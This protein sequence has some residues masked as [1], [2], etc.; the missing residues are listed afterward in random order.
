VVHDLP[1]VGRN[2]Q[3]HLAVATIVACREP[4]SLLAARTAGNLLR[5]LLLRRGMLTS[6]IAEACAF[7]RTGADRPAPDL[8]LIFAP[9]PFMR[10]GLV[11]PPCHGITIGAVCLQPRSAGFVGLRSSTATP[12]IQPGYLSDPGDE[13]LGV[14]VEGVKLAR[15]IFRA[16]GLARYAGEAIE[17]GPEVHTDDEL[18]RFIRDHA[19]TLYHPVGTCRMGRDAG[20]VVDPDLRVHGIQALRVVDAS[21]MPTINRGHT[22]APTIMIA[23]RAA[24]LI[25]GLAGPRPAGSEAR[26]ESRPRGVR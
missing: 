3:D 14:L 8:E 19:E 11:P 17:P 21:V 6:N 15:R 20:A 2:L 12:E 24:D 16:P 1:G 5:F 22:A 23:E 18:A 9:V 26:Q 25:R 7:V 4:V 10:H 13:D